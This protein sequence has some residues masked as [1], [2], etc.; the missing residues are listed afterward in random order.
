MND[1]RD[2]GHARSVTTRHPAIVRPLARPPVVRHDAIM[3]DDPLLE[4]A[5]ELWSDLAGAPVTFTEAATTVAVSPEPLLC[6]PGWIGIVT[7]GNAA[8]ATAPDDR[9]A[10]MLRHALDDLPPPP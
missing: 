8:I 5:R 6:L 1:P 2:P 4:R 9:T 3:T 10:E 7:L